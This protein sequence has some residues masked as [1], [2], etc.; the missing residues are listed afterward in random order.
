MEDPIAW[1]KV[2][3]FDAQRSF[4]DPEFYLAQT[5]RQKL[6]RWQHFPHDELPMTAEIPAWLG[7]YPEYSFVGLDVGFA[8]SGVPV[9]QKDHPLTRSPDLTLL[10]PV[11]FKTSGWMPRLLRWYDSLIK[12]SRD[13][14]KITLYPDTGVWWRGCLDL[15][16]ELRGFENFISDTSERPEF[17][18]DLLDWLVE[19]RC[20]W[21]EGFH[22]HFGTPKKPM[23]IGDDWI[24]VPFISPKIFEDFVLP[25]YL[26]IEKFHGGIRS[27]HSCGNQVPLQKHLLQIQSLEIME[28]SPWSDLSQS[29]RNIP[30]DKT[31]SV[32]IHPNDVLVATNSEMRSQLLDMTRLLAGRN[33]SG[34]HT[35][36]LT[37]L[38][39][40]IPAFI[41]RVNDWT[42]AA[43]NVMMQVRHSSTVKECWQN[44]RH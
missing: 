14:L 18:H 42:E 7:H 9:I 41:T 5:L 13:R 35:S 32:A 8:A 26:E 36:G 37:P 1:A 38:S 43:H 19:Q 40:D 10:Q 6:W 15:A 17:L 33:F 12:I 34:I 25:R 27:I 3:Q 22:A 39:Q 2:F 21:Y 11:N 28:V 31:L 20:R 23:F 16:I 4:S 24:N 44:Q 29:L 30:P